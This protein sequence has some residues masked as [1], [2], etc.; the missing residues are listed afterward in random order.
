M[1]EEEIKVLIAESQWIVREGLK[2]LLAR[3]SNFCTVGEV[4]GYE[5]FEQKLFETKPDIVLIDFDESVGFNMGLFKSIL[6]KKNHCE[7][8]VFSGNIKQ[9]FIFKVIDLGAVGVI[10]KSCED[11][12]IINALK[13]AKKGNKYF[14]GEVL[15]MML[16][17]RNWNDQADSKEDLSSRELEV[18]NWICHGF[19]NKEVASKLFLS[20]HTIN[21]HRKNIMR[22]MEVKSSAEL[23]SCAIKKGFVS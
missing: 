13:S 12:E 11:H 8:V 20:V 1:V 4:D 14:C 22:K 18:L 23:I 3:Q 9:S 2:S 6:D 21:T 15:E 5:A 10:S 16:Q 19:T 7:V 17:Q